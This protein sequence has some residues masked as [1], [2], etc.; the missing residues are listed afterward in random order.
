MDV[1]GTVDV[2]DLIRE[3]CEWAVKSST[4]VRV[5]DAAVDAFAVE[6]LH[7][8]PA[9]QP[10]PGLP[11][12]FDSIDAEIDLLTTLQLLN[13]GSGYRH[14]LHAATGGGAWDTMQRGI[15]TLHITGRR[16][17]AAFLSSLTIGD[18]AELWGVPLDRDVEIAPGIQQAKPGPLAPLARLI[19]RAC[20]EAGQVLRNRGFD[21]WAHCFRA[22]A[23]AAASRGAHPTAESFVR[24]L[25][26]TF[27]PFS[28]HAVVVRADSSR[29]DV[30]ILK[31]AQVCAARLSRALGERVPELF[32][33][34]DLS[35][36]TA[37]ADNVLPAVLRA[38]GVLVLAPALASA[39]DGRQPLPAG[40]ASGEVDLRAAAV[41]ACSRIVARVHA[42]ASAAAAEPAAEAAALTEATLDEYLWL[43]G[44][45]PSMRALERHA[46][47]DTYFY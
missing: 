38:T 34:P 24:F 44:K 10:A 37:G 33:F 26:D 12:V 20:N 25:S 16:P 23:R 35:R 5:D 22:W 36:L 30:W 32:A 9:L 42:L 17:D 27:P 13:F 21:G 39:V 3:S 40:A 4:L 43:R 7:A 19:L 14:E 11:L 31:K 29:R 46:T 8:P 18:V 47:P 1:S 28:D 6:L 2:L 15:L 41:V 45:S